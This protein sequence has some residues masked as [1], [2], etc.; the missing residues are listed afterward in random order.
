M[1]CT[2]L[3]SL[4]GHHYRHVSG[5]REESCD[6]S[7]IVVLALAPCRLEGGALVKAGRLGE[8]HRAAVKAGRREVTGLR[9]YRSSTSRLL[10]SVL[11]P[12][13]WGSYRQPF[14]LLVPVALLAFSMIESA[15]ICGLVRL[16]GLPDGLIS[17][18]SPA[19][20]LAVDLVTVALPADDDLLLA[21]SAEEKAD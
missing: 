19:V 20:T 7:R 18:D 2:A 13:R 8:L 21:P 10:A 17:A 6:G 15:V 1:I 9:R 3:V 14:R 16:C 5:V 4:S 12:L 11:I